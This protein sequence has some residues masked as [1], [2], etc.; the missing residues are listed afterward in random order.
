MSLARQTMENGVRRTKR[1]VSLWRKKAGAIPKAVVKLNDARK[2]A[3]SWLKDFSA[4]TSHRCSTRYVFREDY[5]RSI[6][7]VRGTGS[8]NK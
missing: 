5:P 6:G 4:A 2:M 8:N 7:N 1:R 3:A